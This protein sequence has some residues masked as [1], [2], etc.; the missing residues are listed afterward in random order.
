MPAEQEGYLKWAEYMYVCGGAS[1]ELL[2]T[3]EIKFPGTVMSPETTGSNSIV[4]F[5]HRQELFILF[6]NA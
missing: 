4:K 2:Y 3:T 1:V 5:K 6:Q